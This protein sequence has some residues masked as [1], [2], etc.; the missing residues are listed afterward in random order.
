M[1]G[2]QAEQGKKRELNFVALYAGPESRSVWFVGWSTGCLVVSFFHSLYRS[3]LPWLANS[4]KN[5]FATRNSLKRNPLHRLRQT[6]HWPPRVL[7]TPTRGSL[8][9]S[10][11][12]VEPLNH[13]LFRLS[14]RACFFLPSVL[15]VAPTGWDSNGLIIKRDKRK[16]SAEATRSIPAPKDLSKRSRRFLVLVPRAEG[17]GEVLVPNRYF[18]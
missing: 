8:L 6:T 14:V 5:E 18:H 3:L 2:E 9:R 1:R 4:I 16:F 12:D 15:F 7:A 11:T 17:E 13:H 10:K